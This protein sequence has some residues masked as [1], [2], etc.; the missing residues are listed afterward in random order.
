MGHTGDFSPPTLET[1]HACVAF[2]HAHV[3]QNHTTYV[4]CK[5]GRGRSTVIVLAYLMQHRGLS[6]DEAHAFVLARRRHISLH[7]KQRAVLTAFAASLVSSSSS[8]S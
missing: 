3:Q 6:L 2:L 1:I 5:A 4:H 7:P 8:S